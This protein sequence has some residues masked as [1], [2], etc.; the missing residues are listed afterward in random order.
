[1]LKVWDTVGLRGTG[2]QDVE[3]TEAFVPEYRTH[4][5]SDGADGTSPG[6]AVN[7]GPLYRLPFGQI[8][9][10]AVS[11]SAIGALQG[12]LDAYTSVAAKRVSTNTGKATKLDPAAL[13]AAA[14]TQAAIDEMKTLLYRNFDVMMEK[15]RAGE[16]IALADR[17]RFRYESSQ[18]ARRCADLCDDLMPL[19]GG[20]AIYLDSPLI[21]YWLDINAARAHV[22]NDPGVI[23]PALGMLQM[24]EQPQEFF[25]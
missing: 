2:S 8:F 24:G 17:I 25:V 18:V 19:L 13:N 1:V 22:A 23:G 21:R 12:A 20:R 16:E 9:V 3:V 14:R 15:L 4:K 6:L 7:T 11:T 5:A 10:R